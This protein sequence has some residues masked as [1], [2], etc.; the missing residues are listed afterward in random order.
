MPRSTPFVYVSHRA[1]ALRHRSLVLV[2]TLFCVWYSNL[3]AINTGLLAPQQ[4]QAQDAADTASPADLS[5]HKL[6]RSAKATVRNKTRHELGREQ[7]PKLER[8]TPKQF[9]E[10]EMEQRPDIWNDEE[11]PESGDAEEEEATPSPSHTLDSTTFADLNQQDL[12]MFIETAVG[13]RS[14]VDAA[15]GGRC[16]PSHGDTACSCIGDLLY[17]GEGNGWCG[18]TEEHKQ[19]SSGRYDCRGQP[20]TSLQHMLRMA[21]EQSLTVAQIR[22]GVQEPPPPAPVAAAPPPPAGQRLFWAAWEPIMAD[23]VW[24]ERAPAVQWTGGGLQGTTGSETP[25]QSSSAGDLLIVGMSHGQNPTNWD[26]QFKGSVVWINGESSDQYQLPRRQFQLGPAPDGKL[27]H[28]AQNMRLMYVQVA[29]SR[30][31]GRGRGKCIG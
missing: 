18:A 21:A 20:V 28:G 19:A 9:L 22:K 16:G 13:G 8:A 26:S 23:V 14:A 25:G 1:R 7:K 17:C 4:P 6:P 29:V 2:A 3:F 31:T 15:A 24:P 12:E 27:P 10:P 5:L 30:H 11:E